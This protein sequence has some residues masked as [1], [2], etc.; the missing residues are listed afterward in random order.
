[1]SPNLNVQ[2]WIIVISTI[3]NVRTVKTKAALQNNTN[4]SLFFYMHYCTSILKG[5]YAVL[6]AYFTLA[7][8]YL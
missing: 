8:K 5:I 2:K 4:S 3:L 7:V 1:M 6:Y